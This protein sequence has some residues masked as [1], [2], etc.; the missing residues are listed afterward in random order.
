M[1]GMGTKPQRSDTLPQAAGNLREIYPFDSR[2][3][4]FTIPARLGCY[5][6]FFNPLDPSPAPARD[7]APELVVYLNQCSEEIP[8][9]YSLAISL[10]IEH[11]VKDDNSEQ[12]CLG[13][14]RSFYQH[15][16]FVTQAHI[17]RKRG[18]AFKYLMV[19]GLCLAIYLLS[20]SLGPA[21]FIWRLLREAILIGGWVF[22]WEA[23][24][25]NFIGMD[26]Q[27]QEIKKFKRLIRAEFHF[28]YQQTLKETA[29]QK[30]DQLV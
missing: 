23:V 5:R 16:I 27:I 20:E 2:S 6:D 24:T 21:A 13:S 19:S 14:L 22:M 8:D 3:G 10:E 11:E 1:D 12:E 9:K 17:S 28:S 4:T 30:T 29:G 25:L 15:D 7:L 18:Q 26:T